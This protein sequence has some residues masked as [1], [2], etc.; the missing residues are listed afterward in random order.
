MNR[1][2]VK[3]SLKGLTFSELTALTTD[4]EVEKATRVR[5]RSE[6]ASMYGITLPIA[7][8]GNRKVYADP[9]TGARY[10]AGVGHPP[11]WYMEARNKNTLLVKEGK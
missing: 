11:A 4:V 2:E 3:E 7:S 10:T 8:N 1:N 5:Q 9:K 6:V